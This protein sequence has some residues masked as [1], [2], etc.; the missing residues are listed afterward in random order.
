MNHPVDITPLP[1]LTAGIDEAG[2]GPLAGPVSVAAVILD[3][4]RPI[5]GLDDSKRLTERRR[6]ALYP[7]IKERALAWHIVLIDH[8]T[9][10]RINILQATLQ[11]MREAL[12]GLTT[13][14]E[15]A[16]IDGNRVPEH[17]AC[18]GRAI[19]GG[20]HLV[21]AISAASILAKV[22]RD[23]YM[24]ELDKHHPGYGFAQHKGYGTAAHLAALKRLGP[25]P[26]HRVSFAPV[27]QCL[28]GAPAAE[29]AG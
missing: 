13:A 26:E 9:I 15:L 27:R 22:E 4:G 20:D 12:L 11:G 19:V 25:C 1:R 18:P 17:L 3:P 7:L 28:A 2:R 24:L 5:D 23:H 16:L 21:A 29:T 10:D 8:A 14:A 6:E